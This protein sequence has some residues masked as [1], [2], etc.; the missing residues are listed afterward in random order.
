MKCRKIEQT[1]AARTA[2]SHYKITDTGD[3]VALQYT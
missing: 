1:E 2:A 3:V